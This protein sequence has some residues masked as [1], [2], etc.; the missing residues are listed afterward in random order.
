M[1]NRRKPTRRVGRKTKGM[2]VRGR[3][4]ALRLIISLLILL[5]AAVMRFG[6]PETADRAA[7]TFGRMAGLD[8][9]YVSAITA[10]GEIMDGD[11]GIK[12]ALSDIYSFA[13]GS[14]DEAGKGA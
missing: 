12:Q 11:R 9:D 8:I 6:F 5:C 3:G 7:D 4:L 2:P 1:G 13:F 14:L 10:L